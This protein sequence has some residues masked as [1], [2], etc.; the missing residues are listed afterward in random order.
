MKKRRRHPELAG[1]ISARLLEDMPLRATAELHKRF[2]QVEGAP[3]SARAK[4]R[5]PSPA[6]VAAF[7]RAAGDAV[8]AHAQPKYVRQGVLTLAV[9]STA[10]HYEL[11]FLRAE[12]AQKM[13]AAFGS[14]VTEVK[15]VLDNK[16]H[17]ELALPV[18]PTQRARLARDATEAAL[19]PLPVLP[20]VEA[21][22]LRRVAAPVADEPELY[23]AIVRAMTRWRNLG[24]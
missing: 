22:A 1:A 3:I 10:W 4:T 6:L 5:G 11:G 8:A 17:L 9:D 14:P 21:L 2:A 20:T 7:R 18:A 12:L 13:T 15:L 19:P 16:L 23:D 24:S